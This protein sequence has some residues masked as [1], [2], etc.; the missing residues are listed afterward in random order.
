MASH[1]LLFWLSL[2]VNVLS[3]R[4]LSMFLSFF[5]AW[6][7]FRQ[8]L[9]LA[10]ILGAEPHAS[11]FHLCPA[12]GSSETLGWSSGPLGLWTSES[13]TWV[14]W[15]EKQGAALPSP[16]HS[17]PQSA[18]PYTPTCSI[19]QK[20]F[21]VLFERGKKQKG[22][23]SETVLFQALNSMALASLSSQDTTLPPSS[24]FL[25]VSLNLFF[26]FSLLSHCIFSLLQPY[27][28]LDC[29]LVPG[30][31]HFLSVRAALTINQA[32]CFVACI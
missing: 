14:H 30:S 21:Q 23:K 19:P 3:L 17:W 10:F 29:L 18:S 32:T 5:Q 11:N 8:L 22:K 27:L 4:K 31:W 25:G 6:I 28:P 2:H 12:E 13:F 26:S 9:R 20:S 1:V 7:L 16:A 24:L 15:I